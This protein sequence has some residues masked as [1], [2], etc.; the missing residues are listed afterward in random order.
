[1]RS[2]KRFLAVALSA[3]MVLSITACG[4]KNQEVVTEQ[5]VVA[6][7]DQG[8]AKTT[9]KR[10]NDIYIGTWW[11][12]HYD[13]ADTKLEDSSDYLVAQEKEDDDE[14]TKAEKAVNRKQLETRFANVKKIEEKYGI[15]FFWKN[16]TYQGVKESINTSILA[17]TPDCDI[18][19]TNAEL[20]IPA[21]ANGYAIDLKELLPADHDL[22]TDQ[23]VMSYLDLGD[24]KACILKR[25]G[26]MANTH[27]LAFNVQLLE[28]NNLEDPRVLWERGEW[29]WDKF[30][31]Y[32]VALTQDTDGDGQV[33]QYGFAGY[34]VDYLEELMLSNGANI[35]ANKTEGLSDSKMTE[36]LQQIYDMNNT[37]NVC[38]PVDRDANENDIRL[39]YRNGNI[40]FWMGDVWLNQQS[41]SDYDW[42]GSLGGKTL[43]FDMAYMHWPV[44]PSGNAETDPM[45]NDVD[46][47]LYIIPAGVEDP[48]TVFNL[49][50]DLWNWYD[51]DTVV[52]DDPATLN[53]WIDASGRTDE[54]RQANFK[55]QTEIMAKTTVDL[56]KSLG[57]NYDLW[58]LVDGTVTPAQFQ[59]TYKQQVQDALD[60]RMK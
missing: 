31:E 1:M 51:G 12:Q 47:E 14:N 40:A 44:G 9:E 43:P 57:V 52:R 4:K 24:G 53:W 49:L 17:G 5:V 55:T 58:S 7:G 37:W 20:A 3:A 33:D 22:F 54:Y 16:L 10:T 8:A 28:E 38:L 11:M 36:V 2:L 35:A 19:L 50:Y 48:L 26:G 34:P 41:G 46:G 39:K 25:Q 42:D 59:E 32:L 21:Q 6:N 60:A 56:W 30:N 15:K 18:Y 13:S 27:P 45:L 29:T 23:V